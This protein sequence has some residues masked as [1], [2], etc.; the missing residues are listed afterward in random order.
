MIFL[1]IL[2]LNLSGEIKVLL[3]LE[4]YCDIFTLKVQCPDFLH[5]FY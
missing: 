5:T 1:R 2:T 3:I 4:L